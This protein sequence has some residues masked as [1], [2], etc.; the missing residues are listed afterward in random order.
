MRPHILMLL[1]TLGVA[2]LAPY[3][4]ADAR[5]VSATL[6]FDGHATTG[7][8]TGTSSRVTGALTVESE[9]R[10]SRGWVEL[11][12]ASLR[13]GNDLRDHDMRKSLEVEK[14]PAIRFV[15]DAVE[16]PDGLMRGAVRDTIGG[17]VTGRFTI[18]GVT[19]VRRVPVSVSSI[20]DTLRVRSDFDLDLA[21]YGIGGLSKMFG[22]LR[23]ERV[24]QIHAQL[25]FLSTEPSTLRRVP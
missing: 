3:E 11:E 19:R 21:D 17:S 22:L 4:P 8:F 24:I 13:T 18:H 6:S 1:T 14:Y 12:A 9:L 10:M 25:Q 2:N 20:G 23:M 5:L 16:L 15:V 7:A